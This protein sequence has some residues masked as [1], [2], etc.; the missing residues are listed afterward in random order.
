MKKIN[1]KGAEYVVVDDIK[2]N[3]EDHFVAVAP[4]YAMNYQNEGIDTEES[5]LKIDYNIHKKYEDGSSVFHI[6]NDDTGYLVG[7][8]G[9]APHDPE[10]T[11][12]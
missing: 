2:M 3:G 12:I 5:L 11:V 1:Y 4:F 7:Y 9:L 8:Y 6:I 10:V